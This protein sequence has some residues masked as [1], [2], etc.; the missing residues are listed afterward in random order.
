MLWLKQ[1]LLYPIRQHFHGLLRLFGI[2]C[3]EIHPE[4]MFA[5]HIPMHHELHGDRRLL[6]WIE[7]HRPD[8]RCG[9]STPF[10]DFNV[11]LLREAQ[12]LIA[13]VGHFEFG[14]Y[15][16]PQRHIAE[17]DIFFVDL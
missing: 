17:I 4:V 13:D 10:D 1:H 3:H 7:D 8:G 2:I 16:L 15:G 5:A 6:T 14:L 12:W 11:R 9:W